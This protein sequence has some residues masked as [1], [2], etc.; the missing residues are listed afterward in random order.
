MDEIVLRGMA[1]WPDV[2]AVYGWLALDH[3]GNWLLRGEPISNPLVIG[4]LGR[5]Y[6]HD[7][8]GRWFVQNGPQRVFVTLALAPFVLRVADGDAAPAFETHTGRPVESP[9]R[10]W[11]DE[12]GVVLIETEHGPGAVH[13]LHLERLLPCFLDAHG[14]PLAEE[15][16]EQALER[17]Q[18][19][20][21]PGLR[22]ACPGGPI[23]VGA[24]RSAD[25][26][27]RL[28]FVLRPGPEAADGAR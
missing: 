7:A 26:P 16:L 12:H 23:E 20:E 22:L 15:A 2:P 19:G 25:A 10:A 3:R 13:D 28:G 17:A 9:S 5:N 4:F 14:R 24:I 21:A 18:A 11:I 1:K 8:Q 27:A 6:G